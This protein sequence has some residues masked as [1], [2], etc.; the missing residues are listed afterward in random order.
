MAT[1]VDIEKYAVL[2][3]PFTESHKALDA[4]PFDAVVPH[5]AKLLEVHVPTFEFVIA[6]QFVDAAFAIGT[7]TVTAATSP[8][9]A[10]APLNTPLRSDRPVSG[11]VIRLPMSK[12]LLCCRLVRLGRFVVVWFMG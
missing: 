8:T 10:N 5:P 2:L 7:I 3:E 9:A 6:Y 11:S 4:A 12:L 1:L